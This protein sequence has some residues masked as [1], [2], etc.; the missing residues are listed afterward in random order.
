MKWVQS[1]KATESKHWLFYYFFFVKG[2]AADATD[3]QQPWGLLCNPMMK[4]ISFFVFPCN[5]AP[6]EWNWQGK[7]E[8]LREKTCP[9]ATLS[10]TNHTWTDPGSNPG[11]RGERPATNP[12]S[13]TTALVIINTMAKYKSLNSE[14]FLTS[15]MIIT[16]YTVSCCTACQWECVQDFIS[17][18][19]LFRVTL[20][21]WYSSRYGVEPMFIS[22]YKFYSFTQFIF[23]QHGY[24]SNNTVHRIKPL[25]SNLISC[26]INHVI[27]K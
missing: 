15:L 3:A 25:C 9:S 27:Q 10:T 14:N 1:A 12:L 6:V 24:S 16:D 22:R 13:H 4:M 19:A 26:L 5:G 17:I 23:R 2:P 11:L 7:T 8:V 21:E 18:F 20:S